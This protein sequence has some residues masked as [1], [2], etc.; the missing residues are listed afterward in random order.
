MKLTDIPTAMGTSMKRLV[1]SLLTIAC[2]IISCG[3][4]N[5]AVIEA[6]GVIEGTDIRVASEVGGK[7]R[8]IRTDEGMTVRQGDTLIVIDETDY[9]MQFRQ[10]AAN[11]EAAEANLRLA[12]EGTR[13]EDLI[14]AEAVFRA[15]EADYERATSL[16]ASHTITRKQF[17]DTEA[18]FISA[19]QTYEKMV[20]G[21]RKDEILA[22]RA[23][24]DQAAAQRDQL[25]KRLADCSITA[26]ASG[27]VTVKSVEP[28][29]LVS[30]GSHLLRI[31]KLDTVKLV[32]YV[33]EEDLASIVLG[34]DAKVMIDGAG[35][36]SF[37][38]TVISVAD[39]AEFTPKNIQTK[40]ERTKLVFGVKIRIP[41]PDGTLKP[42]MPADALLNR[43][44]MGDD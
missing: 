17:D 29:E 13:R 15:A 24:R 37:P 20:S 6:S 32:I 4:G 19:Q 33:P 22:A 38:G 11:A 43:Q 3:D 35:E 18:R 12:I 26:P 44:G 2:G 8:A 21:L 9:R 42:G 1:P 7:I 41:N 31:T 10:A 36:R 39:V 23:R 40:E 16:L 25:A 34:Q 30:H 5:N 28:G 14:Q 27:V